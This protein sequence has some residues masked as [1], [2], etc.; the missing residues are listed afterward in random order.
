MY[1]R[2]ELRPLGSDEVFVDC[3]AFDGD[4]ALSFL[5]STQGRFKHLY[6]FEPD[7]SNFAKLKSVVDRQPERDRF[8][9]RQAAVGNRNCT[10]QFSGDATASSA[11]G[12]GDLRV[13]CITLDDELGAERPTII[14][15]DIEGFEPQA[16]AG[17][18]KI[19]EQ[20]APLLAISSYHSQDHLW[21][22]PLQIREYNPAYRFYLRPHMRDV[23]DLVCYAVP[24]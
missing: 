12:T 11:V 23:W 21:K 6:G 14:K 19:I 16:L 7:P 18:R 5:D 13:K 20:D 15:M 10:L 22:I 2:E 17:A 9:I 8:T 1:F 3:G 24:G 4:T